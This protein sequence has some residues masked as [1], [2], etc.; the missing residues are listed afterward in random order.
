MIH[1]Y[2]FDDKNI[3]LDVFSGSIHLVDEVAFD[4]IERYESTPREEIKA[5]ILDKY[6]DRPDVNEAE[7]EECFSD[8]EALKAQGKLFAPD[9]YENIAIDLKK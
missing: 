4:I 7:I 9:K 3:V 8:I 2:K 5:F 1:C 6:S